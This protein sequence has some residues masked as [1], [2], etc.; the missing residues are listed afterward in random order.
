MRLHEAI[1]VGGEIKVVPFCNLL[2]LSLA[3]CKAKSYDYS[4]NSFFNT[5]LL[6]IGG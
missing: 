3:M 1:L 2:L 6:T 4:A 5:L